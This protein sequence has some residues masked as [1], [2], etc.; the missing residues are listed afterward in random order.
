MLRQRVH[1]AHCLIVHHK[2]DTTGQRKSDQSRRSS[3]PKHSYTLRL[4]HMHRT[5]RHASVLVTDTLHPRLDV[6]ERHTRISDIVRSVP[7]PQ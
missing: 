3:L 2:G 5:T 7:L 4:C 6:V 1:H